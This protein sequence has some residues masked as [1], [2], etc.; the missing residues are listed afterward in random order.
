LIKPITQRRIEGNPTGT[1]QLTIHRGTHEIGGSCVE[2]SSNSGHTR[3]II[4]IGLPLVNPDMSP[5]EWNTYQ[6]HSTTQLVAE[7]ILPSINGLYENTEPSVTAVL[8]S[9]A[10]IDHYG[11]LRFVHPDIPVYMSAGTKGL[12]EVSNIFLDTSVKLDAVKT[13]DMRN[14]FQMGEF[15][16][17][18]YLV[19]H[20]APDAVAFLIE[21]DGK[22]IFYTGDFRG[23]GRKAIL[24][25]RFTKNPPSNID[26]LIMEGSM[27]GRDEGLYPDEKAVE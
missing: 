2:L 22:R 6:D 10:H 14:T 25:D 16:I 9:H 12:A 24:L 4:D 3:I 1:M 21:A 17:K 11:L 13:I 26:Y 23:H 18:P 20:S 15:T 19:D 27:L 8:L 7:K 5:F